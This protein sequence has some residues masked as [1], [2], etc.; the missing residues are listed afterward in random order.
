MSRIPILGLALVSLVTLAACETSSGGSGGVGGMTQSQTIGTGAG[1]VAGGL[2]G[3]LISGSTSG[4]LIGAAAGGLIGNRLG[5][6]LEG[7]EKKAAALAAVRAAES[8]TG[9]RIT[10]KRSGVYFQDA[11]NGWA[12]PT[13]AE[14]R[15]SSGRTCRPIRQSATKN[16]NTQEDTINLCKGPAGWMPS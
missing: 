2:A 13:G 9:E 6:Y 12:S 1:A 10:W 5:N 11:A 16:G 3:Y 8:P 14:F 15:D 7:D 4:T